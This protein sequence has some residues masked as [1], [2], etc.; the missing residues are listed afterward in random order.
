MEGGGWGTLGNYQGSVGYGIV[1][2]H[3]YDHA[4]YAYN[5]TTGALVWRQDTSIDNPYNTDYPSGGPPTWG[6]AVLAD[7]KVYYSSGEHSPA[8]PTQRGDCLYCID[9]NTGELIFRLPYVKGER[10][11][12]GYG[13]SCGMLWAWNQ[14]DGCLYMLGKGVSKTTVSAS[15]G[16]I[17]EGASV[18]VQGRV[19]DLSSG[20]ETLAERF[21]DGVP[22]VAD[23]GMSD[24]MA[25]LYTIGTTGPWVDLDKVKGVEVKIDVIDSN[26][27]HYNVG[28]ATADKDGF[29]S[30]SWK[31]DITG[32]Y[33][34][35]ATFEG[36]K[37]YYASSSEAAF[38]L[39]E[40]PEAPLQPETPAAPDY[41]PWLYGILGGVIAAI[42]I[43]LAALLISMRKR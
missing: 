18:L 26:N 21:P 5:V 25:Y 8:S 40:A 14:Y 41:M 16:V 37:S 38:V 35:I 11:F 39:D 9:V 29:F 4:M 15:S 3:S 32:D 13:I 27:N 10:S 30:F 34:V 1:M 20:T 24:W 22:A 7:N 28:T 36:S 31:P 12:W 23:D 33:K 2:G 42:V 19:T 6:Y 43:G 17:T